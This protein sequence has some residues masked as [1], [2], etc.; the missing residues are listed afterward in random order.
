[1]REEEA[2]LGITVNE[3]K[4][5]ALLFMDDLTSLA[6]GYKNKEGTLKA[7]HEFGIRHKIEWGEDKCKVMEIG[8]HKEMRS[9]W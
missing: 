4:I 3:H 6:E 9:E 7:I 2:D 8:K 1:M 5:P